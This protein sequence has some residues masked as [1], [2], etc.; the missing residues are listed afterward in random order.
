MI[1]P[2]LD[3]SARTQNQSVCLCTCIVRIEK[4]V[5]A[6]RDITGKGDAPRRCQALPKYW[7]AEADSC[8]R[9]HLWNHKLLWAFLGSSQ[10]HFG[11]GVYWGMHHSGRFLSAQHGAKRVKYV[12]GHRKY[13][14]TDPFKNP[15]WKSV[16][17]ITEKIN[18]FPENSKYVIQYWKRKHYLLFLSITLPIE[19]T[20]EDFDTEICKHVDIGQF[21][22]HVEAP[23]VEIDMQIHLTFHIRWQKTLIYISQRTAD[24]WEQRLEYVTTM[25][26]RSMYLDSF[27]SFEV[28][29][30]FNTRCAKERPCSANELLGET[31]LTYSGN[32]LMLASSLTFQLSSRKLWNFQI[33]DS[34]LEFCTIW[35]YTRRQDSVFGNRPKLHPKDLWHPT[36]T[37]YL[38]KLLCQEVHVAN[39]W[40]KLLYRRFVV[41]RKQ[42]FSD[43]RQVQQRKEL[44][45]S[46]TY[47]EY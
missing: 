24:L 15:Y 40:A 11:N 1:G 16:I 17:N 21:L 33:A 36:R 38:L 2:T 44:F 3:V 37:H 31:K 22:G 35:A 30:L 7:L 14:V 45:Y 46:N 47:L 39:L 6:M 42:N 20:R 25:N 4:K 29:V 26:R 19:N 27:S 34:I 41:S 10:Y 8:L 28:L 32:L 9:I 23:N 43:F 13:S 12:I 18:I 5:S